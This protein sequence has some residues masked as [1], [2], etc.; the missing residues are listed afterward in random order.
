MKLNMKF[1]KCVNVN[2][3]RVGETFIVNGH[4]DTVFMLVDKA[5]RNHLRVVNLMTGEIKYPSLFQYD[6]LIQ[7]DATLEYVETP[8]S[9]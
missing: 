6:D 5:N 4:P 1:Q 8:L 9:P 3:L 2:S 7:V